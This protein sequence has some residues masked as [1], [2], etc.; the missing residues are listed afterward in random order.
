MFLLTVLTLVLLGRA[1]PATS[2]Q[3]EQ[4]V[5]VEF[6]TFYILHH[7]GMFVQC[8]SCDSEDGGPC[9]A[10]QAGQQVDR[11]T[12]LLCP[13]LPAV[14]G[15]PGQGGLC[16]HARQSTV[17]PRLQWQCGGGGG[18]HAPGALQWV[19]QLYSTSLQADMQQCICHGELCNKDWV[20]AGAERKIQCYRSILFSALTLHCNLSAQLR[21][22]RGRLQR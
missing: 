11:C 4:T 7:Y 5:K 14:G 6:A 21:Q 15:L 12:A 13:P 8:Y 18:L 22:P 3:P 9:D 1:S 20:S 10:T 2:P 17:H 19:G 16:H